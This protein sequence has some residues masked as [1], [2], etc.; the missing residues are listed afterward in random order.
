VAGTRELVARYVR[1]VPLLRPIP[2]PTA[3]TK[4]EEVEGLAD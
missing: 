1:P 4:A 3:E 2:T